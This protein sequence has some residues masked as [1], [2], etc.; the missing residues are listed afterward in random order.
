MASSKPK[1]G[2]EN[3]LTETEIHKETTAILIRDELSQDEIRSIVSKE[4]TKTVWLSSDLRMELRGER[5]PGYLHVKIFETGKPIR[6]GVLQMTFDL[7]VL[8]EGLSF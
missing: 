4:Q 6:K 3:N 1:E 7:G 5:A 2:S 8:R